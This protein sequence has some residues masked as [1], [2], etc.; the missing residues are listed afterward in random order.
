MKTYNFIIQI[1]KSMIPKSFIPTL[2][3]GYEFVVDYGYRYRLQKLGVNRERMLILGTIARSGTHYTLFLLANYLKIADSKGND[4]TAVRPSEMNQMFPNNWHL[5]YL[6]SRKIPV[7]PIFSG[8][9]HKPT[10]LLDLIGLNDI[11]RSHVLYQTRFWKKSPVLHIYRNPLDYAV[12]YYHYMHK[13][14]KSESKTMPNNPFEVLQMQFE[15]YVAMYKS[16]EAASRDCNR[17]ILRMSYEDIKTKPVPCLRIILRWIGIEPKEEYL[18][19]AVNNSSIEVIK[20]MESG[21][22]IVNPTANLKK[23]KFARNGNIGQWRD[24]FDSY[25]FSEAEKMFKDVGINL[26]DFTLEI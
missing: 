8:K 25:Q 19:C 7:G 4:M 2:R 14:R 15:N 23:G 12:S 26:S 9:H 17:K 10:K 18:E 16:Y 6:N 22:E 21:G 24:Y 13:N 20:N 5:S 1:G 11:S 3:Y